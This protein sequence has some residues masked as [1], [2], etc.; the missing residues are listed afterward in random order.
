MGSEGWG[1]LEVVVGLSCL[2]VLDMR[3][4][5]SMSGVVRGEAIQ[6]RVVEHTHFQILVHVMIA[7]I[8]TR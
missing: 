8:T 7:L 1:G 4:M 3:D 5:Y 6:H 2:F